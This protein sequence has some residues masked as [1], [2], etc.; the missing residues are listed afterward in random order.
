MSSPSYVIISPVRNES[1]YLGRTI[2]SVAAQIHRPERWIIVDDG[3]SDE[4]PAL[5]QEAAARHP[6]IVTVQRADRGC[7]RAGSGVMEAF[8]AGYE[9]VRTASAWRYL[10]KLDGDV[11]LPVDYFAACLE[12]FERD[13]RVGIGG[14]LV[15]V[16]H[17]ERLVAEY[18]DPP[19]HVRGPSKIYR[20]E[21]WE[22]IGGLISAPGWDTYD[23]IKAQRLGWSTRTFADVLLV[24]CRPTGGAYGA[25][26]NWVK[27]GAA[28]YVV[29]YHPLFMML[30]CARRLLRRPWGVAGLGLLAGYLRGYL[31]K[32]PQVPDAATISY[33]RREQL[34]FLSGRR[35][36]WR[37]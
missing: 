3:S 22:A 7:R 14:G 34:N 8:Y 29:G 36:L 4:T 32:L 35:S 9:L 12:R 23:L 25:W 2:D 21:C 13:P 31:R 11:E 19:F 20:R 28:N 6:W 30:K 5:L 24:H 27:N 37:G 33:L 1:A 18:R 16:R 10:A 17:G 15:C 26:S